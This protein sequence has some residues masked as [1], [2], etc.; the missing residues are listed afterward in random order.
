MDLSIFEYAIPAAFF[1]LFGFAFFSA[2]RAGR[3]QRMDKERNEALFR[4]MFPDL[5]PLFHP[6]KLVEFVRARRTRG[7]ATSANVWKSPPGFAADRAEIQP[8][9][10]RE[11]IRLL[12]AAGVLLADFLFEDHAEG[13]VLRFGKGKF[14]VNVRDPV[15]RVRYW[16]PDREFKWSRQ[17]GWWFFNRMAEDSFS[18]SDRSSSDSSSDSS[19]SRGAAAAAGIVAAGGAFDGGGASQAWDAGGSAGSSAG[20]AESAPATSY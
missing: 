19:S 2:L 8:D 20:G 5:Q 12:D 3:R 4:S 16:H 7:A 14:T 18:S 15:P 11:K 6:E 1:L 17:K 13:G 10:A 9:G